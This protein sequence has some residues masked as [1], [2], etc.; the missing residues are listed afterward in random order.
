MVV[1]G[2]PNL[3]L[4]MY[5]GHIET[6]VKD[7][8]TL[9]S[10]S[11]LL[12]NQNGSEFSEN[13]VIMGV[14]LSVK[15]T[16]TSRFVGAMSRNQGFGANGNRNKRIRIQTE[17]DRMYVFAD[18]KQ[19]NRCFVIMVQ[20]AQFARTMVELT[21]SIPIV[22]TPYFIV[23][24]TC[25]SDRRTM[26]TMAIIETRHKLI[27]LKHFI[28]TVHPLITVIPEVKINGDIQSG[29]QRYFVLHNVQGV[30]LSLFRLTKE[31]S[32]MGAQ[33]DKAHELDVK[34]GESCGCVNN[35]GSFGNTVCEM[36]VSFP[37]PFP[38]AVDPS[39][40]VSVH[41]FRSLRTSRLF[42]KN[43][44]AY[45]RVYDAT[46]HHLTIRTAKDA[47]VQHI[48]DNEGWTIVGWFRRGEITDASNEAERVDSSTVNVHISLLVPTKSDV[49]ETDAFKALLIATPQ[50]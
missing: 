36:D 32:C 9:I 26:G 18:L 48:H 4:Q 19:R 22:G 27:P 40:T 1:D 45:S 17:W 29:E 20:R 21:Q 46:A 49:M 13:K 43:L 50:E 10:S 44:D 3:A 23:E 47:I 12:E 24:P 41:H 28:P 11:A 30:R 33:C 2:D 16:S 35:H 39:P 31:G 6:L 38:A 15:H 34:K 37:N 25:T 42:F 5:E 8:G 14:C 7:G